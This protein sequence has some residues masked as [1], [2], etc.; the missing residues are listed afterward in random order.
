MKHLLSVH[1]TSKDYDINIRARPTAS[2]SVEAHHRVNDP[3]T[4]RNSRERRKKEVCFS[5]P[6]F[7]SF[8]YLKKLRENKQCR[9]S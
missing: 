2:P 8:S 1:C 7:R 9:L 6:A 3:N 4:R 5:D